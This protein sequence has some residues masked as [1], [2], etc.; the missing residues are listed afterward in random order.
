MRISRGAWLNLNRPVHLPRLNLL[1]RFTLLG[2]VVTLLLAGVFGYLLSQRM[3]QDALQDSADETAVLVTSLV[4]PGVRAEDFQP[5]S[6]TTLAWRER[7]GGVAGKLGGLRVKVWNPQGV[8]VYSDD[9]AQ[10]GQGYSLN[11][12]FT[13]AL[14]GKVAQVELPEEPIAGS[15]ERRLEVYIPVQVAGQV[16][17]VYQVS[18]P[19]APVGARIARI[20]A[21]VWGGSLGVFVVLFLALYGLLR[22]ASREIQRMA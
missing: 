10:I 15:G 9:L 14:A 16:V 4:G 1:Q 21:L 6:Q 2:L 19:F 18:R 3:T 20:Q 5:G 22:G 13:R 17:G 11:E 7:L 8:L 12:G